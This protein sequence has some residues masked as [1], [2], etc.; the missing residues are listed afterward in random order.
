MVWMAAKTGRSTTAGRR[1]PS[2]HGAPE[3]LLPVYVDGRK[4]WN[5]T[6][7]GELFTTFYPGLGWI[8]SRNPRGQ[9][10]VRD[11]FYAFLHV[12]IHGC[13]HFTQKQNLGQAGWLAGG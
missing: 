10:L 5:A 9:N 11:G 6:R 12:S 8:A 1:L 7:H 2:G 4:G 3:L 13:M